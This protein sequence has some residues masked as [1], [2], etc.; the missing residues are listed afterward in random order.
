V[1][2]HDGRRMLQNSPTYV[3][4][5]HRCVDLAH[6]RSACTPISP[7]DGPGAA[8][9]IP[10]ARTSAAH[11]RAC[12]AVLICPAPSPTLVARTRCCNAGRT[13]PRLVSRRWPALPPSF[14]LAAALQPSRHDRASCARR[15]PPHERLHPGVSHRARDPGAGVH[16]L[17][18]R[19]RFPT[20]HER[21]LTPSA[22]WR[23]RAGSR[24]TR[25][26]HGLHRRTTAALARAVSRPCCLR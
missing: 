10:G 13:R 1:S 14:G 5:A 17:H 3:S 24:Q 21:L 19:H 25:A 16:S 12:T 23:P 26:A 4:R 15:V 18:Q 7:D 22:P 6:D 20:A 9:R 8:L 2:R 11:V